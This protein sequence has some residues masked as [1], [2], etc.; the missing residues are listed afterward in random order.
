M[1]YNPN[2]ISVGDD[3]RDWPKE[4]WGTRDRAR[5]RAEDRARAQLKAMTLRPER[6][7]KPLPLGQ[8]VPGVS[9]FRLYEKPRWSLREIDRRLEK[10]GVEW[11]R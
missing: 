4:L 1:K 11:R 5:A 7:F 9:G 2:I 6:E 10:H 3:F 8:P